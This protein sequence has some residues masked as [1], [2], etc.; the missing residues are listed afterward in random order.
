MVI[1]H[2]Y[3]YLF[4]EVPATAST[5]I[6]RELRAQYDGQ[7]ILYK[8]ANYSEFKRMATPEERRYFRFAGIRN[9][10]DV[11]VSHYLRLK[12]NR[13][14]VYTDATQYE[15][16]G[17]WIPDTHLEKFE[18]IHRTGADFPAFVRRFHQTPFNEWV[19]LGARELD[20]VIRF[21]RLQ[22]DFA[23]VL[24]KIGITQV[25]DLPV[26]NTV[27]ERRPFG[28]YYPPEIRPLV[29]RV[30][31]PFMRKWGYDFPADWNITKV[32][33]ASRVRFTALDAPS[34]LAA[35]YV[36]M[37]PHNRALQAVKDVL[38]RV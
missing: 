32:P 23:T 19:L 17:G 26:A 38:R 27:G 16:N 22:E 9:P 13:D 6:S 21:E 4:V 37:S 5:A 18:F 30:F 11:T 25:R 15:R 12:K 31:G 28:E 34:N 20:F 14:G 7:L 10:L 2:K 24:R 36:A 33:L 8:H 3:R 29:V 35:R 1:S